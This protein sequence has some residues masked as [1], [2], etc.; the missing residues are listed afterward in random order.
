MFQPRGEVEFALSHTYTTLSV[1]RT[2][3]IT[4]DVL[5]LPAIMQPVV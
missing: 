1:T 5:Y 4:K 2:E 3:V